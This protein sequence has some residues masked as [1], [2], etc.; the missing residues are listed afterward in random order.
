MIYDRYYVFLPTI[1]LL[2]KHLYQA[3][4][5]PIRPQIYIR[6]GRRDKASPVAA[7]RRPP[8]PLLLPHLLTVLPLLPRRRR[9]AVATTDGSGD[10]L[11]W[12]RGGA[13]A[14]MSAI[15]RETGRCRVECRFKVAHAT[16][17]G[18]RR[19][20]S[21]TAATTTSRSMDAILTTSDGGRPSR[22]VNCDDDDD[23]NYNCSN[24]IW[25]C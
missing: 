1:A 23:D 14:R 6:L 10:E 7:C 17:E 2:R 25:V 11:P 24:I 9:L 4:E 12:Q 22:I 19:S 8:A 21:R 16:G 18:G 15:R 3:Y 20:R 13:V 5:R